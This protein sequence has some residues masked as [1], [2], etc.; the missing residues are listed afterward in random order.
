M[1][2]IIIFGKPMITR[3]FNLGAL[4]L[5]V[6]P[7]LQKEGELIRAV[8][9]ERD[10]IGGWKRRSGYGTF[11]GTA[12]GS[13]ITSLWSWLRNDGT[14]N[15]V[16]RVSGG[17]V[18]SS[19]QGTGAFTVT[20]NGTLTPGAYVGHTV[21]DDVMII[22]DGVLATRHSSNGTSFTDTTSAPLA[23]QFDEFQGRVWAA[24]GTAL[25]GTATDLIYSSVGTASGWVTDSSSIR[26]PGAGRVNSVFK[27]NDRIVATKEA[28][29]MFRYDG[30][31]LVDLATDM[32]P[33]SPYAIGEVEGYRNWPNRSLGFIA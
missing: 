1:E 18:Y 2:K 10:N 22:G 23:S 6:S 13:A 16:Y 15:Y 25:T 33:S 7:M 3:V 14:T 32:G 26:I 21:V 19:F 12:N 5:K 30:D 31:S 11:L 8:N 20:G 29:N 28:L 27:A 17:I 9:V 4:N 24:K